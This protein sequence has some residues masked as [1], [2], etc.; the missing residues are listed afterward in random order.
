MCFVEPE[1][2]SN[3]QLWMYCSTIFY[4][5]LRIWCPERPFPHIPFNGNLVLGGK[6]KSLIRKIKNFRSF[7][8]ITTLPTEFLSGIR[9]R[10]AFPE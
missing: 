4:F 7:R 5:S 8:C 2:G 1:E 9:F 3:E 6:N 10:P